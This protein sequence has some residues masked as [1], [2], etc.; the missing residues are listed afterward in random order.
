VKACCELCKK[1]VAVLLSS[2]KTSGI[3][4][5]MMSKKIP[6]PSARKIF[7]ENQ[8]MDKPVENRTARQKG[9]LREVPTRV[10]VLFCLL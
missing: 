2:E 3:K 5:A 7:I 4:E 8:V 1:V 6:E 10:K 9:C